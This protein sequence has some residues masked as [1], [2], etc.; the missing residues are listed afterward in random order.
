MVQGFLFGDVRFFSLVL[1]GT[2]HRISKL[3]RAP[4]FGTMMVTGIW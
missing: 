4:D 3:E 1:G 2:R